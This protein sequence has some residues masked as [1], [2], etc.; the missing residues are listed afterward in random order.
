M[1]SMVEKKNIAKTYRQ[2]SLLL[3]HGHLVDFHDSCFLL[4][5]QAQIRRVIRNTL[6]I[7]L[8]TKNCDAIYLVKPRF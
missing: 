1:N 6:L 4:P 3:S 5:A 8:A 2:Y 7:K